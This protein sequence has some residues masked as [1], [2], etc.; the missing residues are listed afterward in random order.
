M[1]TLLDFLRVCM[2]PHT[3]LLI[4]YLTTPYVLFSSPLRQ[5]PGLPTHKKSAFALMAAELDPHDT[6]QCLAFS[7]QSIYRVSKHPNACLA[8]THPFFSLLPF[9]SWLLFSIVFLGLL[10]S[11]CSFHWLFF[12]SS[13]ILRLHW[14]FTSAFCWSLSLTSAS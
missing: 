4:C 10:I 6:I 5:I 13:N 1:H 3:T 7:L 11:C 9:I 2:W 12:L 14:L 8:S